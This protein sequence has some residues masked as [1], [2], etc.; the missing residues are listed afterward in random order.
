[1][2]QTSRRGRAR[3]WAAVRVL[4]GVACLV[5]LAAIVLLTFPFSPGL[6]DVLAAQHELVP[7][8]VRESSGD[9]PRAAALLRSSF[10]LQVPGS[11]RGRDVVLMGVEYFTEGGQAL[12]SAS[13]TEVSSPRARPRPPFPQ[14]DELSVFVPP[15]NSTVIKL[16]AASPSALVVEPGD[17][18]YAEIQGRAGD[19]SFNVRSQ[20][21]EPAEPAT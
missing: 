4:M 18:I 20:P 6:P 2:K 7:V 5:G 1:M 14:S 3:R 21:V 9:N 10:E 12:G 17:R 15:L 8:V 11:V 16:R 19:R 13:V